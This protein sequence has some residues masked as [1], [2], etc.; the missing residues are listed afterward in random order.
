MQAAGLLLFFLIAF[1]IC[2]FIT[3]DY[4]VISHPFS[5]DW[6]MTEVKRSA[7]LELHNEYEKD[8]KILLADKY[9]LIALGGLHVYP[10]PHYVSPTVA[11]T[12]PSFYHYFLL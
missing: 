12:T 7:Q 8:H 1:A 4:Y 3:V 5:N 2:C 11:H 6:L 9:Y 10:F